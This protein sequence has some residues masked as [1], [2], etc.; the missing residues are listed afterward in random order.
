[1]NKIILK[2]QT[3]FVP[4]HIFECGQAFRWKKLDEEKYR[5][6][7]RDMVLEAHAIDDSIE[8]LGDFS[9]KNEIL[10]YFDLNTNYDAIKA[11]LSINDEILTKAISFGGG[12]RIF[13]QDP[14]E[15]YISFIIS[16]NNQIKN[17]KNTIRKL[18]QMYGEK[19][20]NPFDDEE[21]YTFPS[22]LA[23]SNAKPEDI[24]EYARAGFRSERIVIASK[25]VQEGIINFD[26]LKE[27]SIDDI[28]K[29][30]LE[31]PGIGEKV[32]QCI[33]L[34]GLSRTDS[35]PVDVWV[36]RVME[37]LYYGGEERNKKLIQED[38]LRRFG[39]LSGYAQ[40]Y[41]FYY[42]R[43]NFKKMKKEEK[44]VDNK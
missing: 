16:A 21:Y 35:F 13:K 1:M 38:G 42:M 34:F 23:L 15:T 37:E 4:S 41:L 26:E 20:N 12:M 43:E 8:I 14:F 24:K 22:P 17:I 3:S 33:L 27:K 32:F 39:D 40:Q 30:L 9:D 19:L 2:G 5:F 6:I 7:F 29:T 10:N 44:N 11:K 31:V 18:S 25:M 36:K 28:R